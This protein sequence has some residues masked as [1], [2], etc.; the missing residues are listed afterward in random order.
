MLKQTLFLRLR[1]MIDAHHTGQ[2]WF[3]KTGNPEM[4]E[5]IP[6][7]RMMWPDCRFIFAK[8]R[9]IENIA[10]RLTKF[11]GLSF[12]YHCADWARNMMSWRRVLG[13]MPDLPHIEIDQHDIAQAPEG[14][15]AA[16]AAFL[17]VPL[18]VQSEIMEIFT[19]DRP[20]QTEPGSAERTLSVS[21]HWL[22]AAG[23]AVFH[24]H[25]DAPMAAYGYTED[26][27]YQMSVCR[28]DGA[29]PARAAAIA[30]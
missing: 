28:R 23:T 7:L 26:E 19:R 27:R 15:A 14:A 2:I 1:D 3:D 4:I 22:D 21:E 17:E 16:L 25:C 11:P 9:A 18:S 10:S 12:E 8:R 29:V 30:G 5:A 6:S 20:Q 24:K 13:A